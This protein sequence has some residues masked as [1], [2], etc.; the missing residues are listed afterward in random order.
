MNSEHKKDENDCSERC[1]SVKCHE[2]SFYRPRAKNPV[3]RAS[4]VVSGEFKLEAQHRAEDF[5]RGAIG[6]TFTR[7]IIQFLGD[8]GN[9]L[10]A[11]L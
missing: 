11:D 8:P 6:Q 10:V 4:D 5:G 3:G 1:F 2:G 7:T 9:A